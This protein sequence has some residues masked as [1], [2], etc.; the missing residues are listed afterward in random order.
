M[1]KRVALCLVDTNEQAQTVVERLTAAGFS[2]D[3]ISVL[4]PDKGSTKEFAHHK[5]TKLPEGATVGAG[6]G[7]LLGGTVGLLAGLGAL[8]VGAEV[9]VRGGGTLA[10]RLGISPI[11]VGLT[12]VSIGTSMPELHAS[13]RYFAERRVLEV[14]MAID[15]MEPAAIPPVIPEL[16]QLRHVEAPISGTLLTRI[17]FKLGRPQ[18]SRL[19]LSLGA[20][21]IRSEWLPTGSVAVPTIASPGRAANRA[22]GSTPGSLLPASPKRAAPSW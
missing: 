12:V 7:G 18:G 22:S 10:S 13:Y 1:A 14:E 4:F 2:Q 15:G 20:G 11:I 19:D 21:R 8:V 17:D 6:T 9:M 16:A 3:D 5:E